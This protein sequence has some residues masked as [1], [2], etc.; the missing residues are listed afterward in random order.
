MAGKY[1][2]EVIDIREHPE[3]AKS[4]QIIATPTLLKKLPPPLRQL[5][6]DLSDTEKV[7]IGLDIQPIKNKQ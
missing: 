2:I 3:I 6:G 4:E 1:K 7:L 5:I